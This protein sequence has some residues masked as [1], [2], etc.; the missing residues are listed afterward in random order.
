[1]S[2]VEDKLKELNL[3]LPPTPK[4]VAAYIPA[5]KTGNLVFTAGQI[6]FVD[7]ELKFKGQLGSNIT[8]EEGYQAAAICCLNALAA[9][10]GVI[11]NLDKIERVV[12]LTVFVNSTST[13]TDQ[14]KVANGASELLVKIFEDVGRHARS[15]VGTNTLPLGAAVEVEM[16][17]QVKQ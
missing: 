8:I 12:K 3:I 17:V 14:A 7:G 15:A 13:F 9:I 1:M 10:K 6:P 16:I 4:P 11:D 5:V 2:K